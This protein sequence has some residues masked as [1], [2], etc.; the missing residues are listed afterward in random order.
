LAATVWELDMYGEMAIDA[1]AGKGLDTTELAMTAAAKTPAAVFCNSFKGLTGV[2]V[3]AK[4]RDEKIQV[5][6]SR[7]CD[8][9]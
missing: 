2:G 4:Q 9:C 7:V 8:T 6:Q 3:S 5:E 1:S